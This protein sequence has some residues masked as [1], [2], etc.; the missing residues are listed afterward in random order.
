MASMSSQITE[1][2]AGDSLSLRPDIAVLDTSVI[3]DAY[4]MVKT[5]IDD[6]DGA[7]IL[8]LHITTTPTSV[9]VITPTPSSGAG[10]VNTRFD[11]TNVQTLLLHPVTNPGAFVGLS[12]VSALRWEILLITGTANDYRTQGTIK[13][14][15]YRL[16]KLL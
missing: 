16:I 10:T 7:A 14:K 9:G 5:K 3:T 4:F 1:F 2:L 12:S 8:T 6:A 11:L 15:A 13:A